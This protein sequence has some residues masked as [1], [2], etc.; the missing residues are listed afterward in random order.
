MLAIRP[1]EAP[2]RD[3]SDLAILPQRAQRS[4]LSADHSYRDTSGDTVR[5]KSTASPRKRDLLT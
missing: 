4:A 2:E 3:T 5:N 1:I